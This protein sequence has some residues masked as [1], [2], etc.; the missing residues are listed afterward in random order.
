MINIVKD[1]V[2][3]FSVQKLEA[4]TNCQEVDK[5]IEVCEDISRDEKDK[6]RKLTEEEK[7][8]KKITEKE[9][10]VK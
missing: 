10:F 6:L 7:S 3:L 1:E 9:M 2:L 5:F 8:T 4:Q